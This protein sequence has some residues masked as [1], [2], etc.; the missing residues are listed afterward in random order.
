MKKEKWLLEKE[1]ILEKFTGKAAWTYIEIPEIKPNK[2]MPFGWVI[3]NGFI[4]DFE[5]E[6]IKLMPKG[7]GNLF[8]AVN[9]K[10]RKNIKKESGDSVI[11]KLNVANA[12]TEIPKEIMECFANEPKKVYTNFLKLK[13][14]QQ[15]TF[16]NWIYTAKNEDKKAEII[17]DMMDKLS[18]GEHFF[19]RKEK[20]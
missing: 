4:D 11:L 5:L 17:I 20:S 7:N 2:N 9:A 15:Q 3:V 18:R 8:L 14:E 16:L 12:P 6:K 19:T 10:I 1:Y 13:K